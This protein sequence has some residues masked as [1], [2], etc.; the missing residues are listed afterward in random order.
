M[1]GEY[2]NVPPKRALGGLK[3]LLMKVERFYQSGEPLLTSGSPD[4]LL[5]GI[6]SIRE[7]LNIKSDQRYSAYQLMADDETRK[8]LGKALC[9]VLEGK[10]KLWSV[11]DVTTD[12]LGVIEAWN[13]YLTYLAKGA[14]NKF[15]EKPLTFKKNFGL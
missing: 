11:S 15:T 14:L 10:G 13:K 1:K 3:D 12:I 8:F 5:R 7:A 9:E 6:K 4:Q 2:D